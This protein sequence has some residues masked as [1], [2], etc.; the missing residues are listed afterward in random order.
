[1]EYSELQREKNIIYASYETTEETHKMLINELKETIME[2][3]KEKER[4][5]LFIRQRNFQIVQF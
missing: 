1:M 2:L 3:T 5:S 4:L